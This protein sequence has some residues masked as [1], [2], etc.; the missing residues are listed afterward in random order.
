MLTHAF[1][2]KQTHK[3]KESPPRTPT[4]KQTTQP[5][6]HEQRHRQQNSNTPQRHKTKRTDKARRSTRRTQDNG[7]TGEPTSLTLTPEPK[8]P[9]SCRQTTTK[10][11]NKNKQTDNTCQ[12]HTVS[13]Q[14]TK[15]THQT[16]QR[17]KARPRREKGVRVDPPKVGERVLPPPSCR[18]AI[19]PIREGVG[20]DGL[21]TRGR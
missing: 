12:Q 14:S 16:A 11:N 13:Y 7:S 18:L 1:E 15:H 19:L 2:A 20:R 21:S 4:T 3:N 10:E 17:K 9:G 8:N 6:Q 5:W